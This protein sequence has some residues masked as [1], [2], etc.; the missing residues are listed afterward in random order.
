MSGAVILVLWIVFSIG[1]LVLY[2][3]IFT[4][5][6]FSLSQGLMKELM[7]AGMV[8]FGLTLIT[9]YLWW[10]AALVILLT[11]LVAAGKTENPSGKKAIIFAFAVAAI[12]VAIVGISMRSN[13]KTDASSAREYRI[14]ETVERMV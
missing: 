6:Y 1:V 2:H 13:N 3:K 11:G 4:V 5:Y 8:G 12:V 10:L 9:L 7:V 14:E